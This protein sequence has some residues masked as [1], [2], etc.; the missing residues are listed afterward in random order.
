MA[1]SK[2][3]AEHDKL[4]ATPADELTGDMTG[5]DIAFTLRGIRF[6]AA[7]TR[8]GSTKKPDSFYSM[9]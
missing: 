6:G 4:P 8:S 1:F 5:D 7:C 9:L 2:D 3:V